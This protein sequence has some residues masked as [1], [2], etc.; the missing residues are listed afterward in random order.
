MVVALCNSLL[1]VTGAIRSRIGIGPSSHE[2]GR[3]GIS[4]PGRVRLED[5]ADLIAHAAEDSEDFTFGAGGMSRVVEAP[6]VSIQLSR[7]NRAN[8][9]CVAAD[10]DDRFHFFG[11]K[12]VEVFGAVAR[13][14]DSDFGHDLN[15]H[16]VNVTGRL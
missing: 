3:V 12:F 14:V 2:S 10:R 6:V 13:D 4:P 16:R 9:V 11:Q 8:L 7:K 5:T 1:R 15:C